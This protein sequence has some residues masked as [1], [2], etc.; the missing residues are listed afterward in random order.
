LPSRPAPFPP[1]PQSLLL[2]GML[3][4][5]DAATPPPPPAYCAV[6]LDGRVVGYASEAAAEAIVARLR[7]LKAAGYSPDAC[8]A[9]GGGGLRGAGAARGAGALAVRRPG[10]GAKACLLGPCRWS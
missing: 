6:Q 7:M 9:G 8:S 5:A 4:A 2:Q 1:N 10:G 3:P